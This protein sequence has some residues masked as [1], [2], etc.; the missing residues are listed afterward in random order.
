MMHYIRLSL[1]R[2]RTGV[3]DCHFH[4]TVSVNIDSFGKHIKIVH[5]EHAI[6]EWQYLS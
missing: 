5:M 6:T 3:R 2:V 4:F 1:I